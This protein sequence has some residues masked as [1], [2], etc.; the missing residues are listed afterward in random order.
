MSFYMIHH[1]SIKYDPGWIFEHTFS[2]LNLTVSLHVVIGMMPK[3]DSSARF[4]KGVV[5]SAW[6]RAKAGS[7]LPWKR[8]HTST[9]EN[10][11]CHTTRRW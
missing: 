2:K 6:A 7:M 9:F 8:S 4:W 5:I 10:I 3:K 1:T 11:I